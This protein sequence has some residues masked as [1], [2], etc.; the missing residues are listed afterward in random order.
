MANGLDDKISALQAA[1]A[2]ETTVEQSAITL[3]NGL[4]EQLAAALQAAQNA[5]ATP[6]QLASFDTLA[7][8]ISNNSTALA[9]S[10]AAN[11]PVAP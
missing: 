11:T 1:V 3:L 4:S 7:G 10:V 8:A 6:E 2:E 5:G 9:A